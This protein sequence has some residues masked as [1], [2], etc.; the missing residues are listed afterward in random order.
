MHAC[1]RQKE[2]IANLENDSESVQ[3][4]LGKVVQQ[5]LGRKT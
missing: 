2:T 1:C 4:E 5:L 3:K